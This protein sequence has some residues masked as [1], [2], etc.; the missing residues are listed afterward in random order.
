MRSLKVLLTLLTIFVLF[1]ALSS[2]LAYG[3]QSSNFRVVKVFWGESE[4]SKIQAA[5]GDE[6]VILTIRLQYVDT[7]SYSKV[8]YLKGTLHLSQGFETPSGE[9]EAVAYYSSVVAGQT[10]DLQFTLNID[11]SASIADHSMRLVI[12]GSGH[13]SPT[14]QELTV[15]VP[16]YGRV[17]FNVQVLNSSVKPGLSDIVLALKNEGSADAS[18]VKVTIS[19]SSVSLVGEDSSFDLGEIGSGDV[20]Y[21]PLKIY[22]QP[23]TLP[24]TGVLTLSISYRDAYGVDRSDSLATSVYV[25]ATPSPR[26]EAS[27][28]PSTLTPGKDNS[29]KLTIENVGEYELSS[30]NAYLVVPQTSQLILR[31][32]DGFWYIQSLKPGE[33]FTTEFTIYAPPS[34]ASLTCQLALTLNY[35]DEFNASH[36]ETRYL[37]VKVEDAQQ[38]LL[39]LSLSSYQLSPGQVN[40]LTLYVVNEGGNVEDITIMLTLPSGSYASP[41]SPLILIGWDGFLHIDKLEKGGFYSQKIMIYAHPDAAGNSYQMSFSLRY[42]DPTGF[43]RS[44][45]RVIGVKVLNAPKP[46][47]ECS[48]TP[49]RIFTGKSSNVSFTISN[50]GN[51]PLSSVEVEISLPKTATLTPIALLGED[52]KLFIGTLKPSTS[53][54][55]NLSIYAHPDAS[56]TTQELTLTIKYRD[57]TGADKRE[58]R[59]VVLVLKG[60]VDIVL[61]EYST[62]PREVTPGSDFSLT[63]TLINLGTSPAYGVNITLEGEGFEPLISESV[64]VGDLP[65]NTPTPFTMA[66]KAPSSIKPGKYTLKFKISYRDNLHEEGEAYVHVPITVQGAV[67]ATSKAKA[68]FAVAAALPAAILALAIWR[69]HVPR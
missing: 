27:L 13:M 63:A 33:N 61:S 38:G 58:T 39:K 29:V 44:E 66:L 64:F 23:S 46:A 36:S 6:N 32:S 65:I 30:I 41:T 50:L 21:I 8:L 9:G 52:N 47:I 51:E 48:F 37:G 53:K 20:K 45:T 11:D 18:N 56:G 1:T 54:T 42:K 15:T 12:E 17:S 59:K 28:T 3:Q 10:F 69:R 24:Y 25:E 67:P 22:A 16:L 62:Y 19:S 14:T 31:N 4:S 57:S 43:T 7:S 60:S 26:L 5:P 55:V 34:S 49:Q 2:T 68:G 40:N 35:M